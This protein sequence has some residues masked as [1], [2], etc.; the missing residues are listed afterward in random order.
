MTVLFELE[1]VSV[2][3]E[4]LLRVVKKEEKINQSMRVWIP[5]GMKRTRTRSWDRG[6]ILKYLNT[7]F[8]IYIWVIDA[9]SLML[10]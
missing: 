9:Q 3:L 8:P 10:T 7:F 5:K 1:T 6:K 2:D 4:Q